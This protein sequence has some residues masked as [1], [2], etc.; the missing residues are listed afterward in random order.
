MMLVKVALRYQSVLLTEALIRSLAMM[1]RDYE[2]SLKGLLINISNMPLVTCPDCG[3]EISNRAEA[4][5]N[6]GYRLPR[7]S[8][9]K[10]EMGVDGAISALLIG[11]GLFCTVFISSSIGV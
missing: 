7:G 1:R 6:C 10:K 9:F 8:I 11:S 2:R 5:I 3:K 4:C